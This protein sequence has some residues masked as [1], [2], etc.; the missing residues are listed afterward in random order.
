MADIS[1]VGVLGSVMCMRRQ[2]LGRG[3]AD[4]GCNDPQRSGKTTSD[5]NLKKRGD[6]GRTEAMNEGKLECLPIRSNFVFSTH[7]HSGQ[8]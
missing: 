5:L 3:F 1:I 4:L 2:R 8:S 7:S 6:R